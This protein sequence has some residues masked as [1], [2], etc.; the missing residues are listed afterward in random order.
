MKK[1]LS[2]CL[3]CY[4]VAVLLVAG[5]ATKPSVSPEPKSD[6]QRQQIEQE[7]KRQLDA[8]KT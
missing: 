4:L 1:R 6:S 8:G 3:V 7:E 2:L 5:C